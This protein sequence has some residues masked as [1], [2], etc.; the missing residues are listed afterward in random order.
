VGARSGD[1]Q[2]DPGGQSGAA[3]C[4]L[5]GLPNPPLPLAGMKV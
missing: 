2:E 5:R 3:L 1:P 4:V